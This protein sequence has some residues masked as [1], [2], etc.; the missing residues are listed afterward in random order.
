VDKI[1]NM[2][3]LASKNGASERS[4]TSGQLFTNLSLIF[5]LVILR[6]N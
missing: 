1:G 6:I 2:P 3:N 4:R 5:Q